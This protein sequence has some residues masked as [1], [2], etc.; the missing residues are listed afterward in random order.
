MS[1]GTTLV[2]SLFLPYTVHFHDDDLPPPRRPS[3]PP[4]TLTQVERKNS[5]VD[6]H[7]QQPA[8][9]F[10]GLSPTPPRT[11]AAADVPEFFTQVQPSAATHFPRPNDPQTLVRSDSH[12]P[13]WSGSGLFFN[14]PRSRAE[15][16]PAG[17]KVETANASYAGRVGRR[18]SPRSRQNR[19]PRSQSKDPR[20]S[21]EWSVVPSPQG[22]GGLSNAIKAAIE[23]KCL[24]DVFMIGLIGF[25]TDILDERKKEEIHEK[26]ESEWDALTVFVSDKDFDGHY[27][28][29]CKIILWPVFHYQIPDHPKSKA[30]GDNSWEFYRNLNQAFANKIVKT[31]KR[32]DIIWVHDYHLLLVPGMIRE[33]LPDAQIGFF[34]H[35]AFP[36]SEVFRC[37]AYRKELL[38]GMLGA[39]LVAFQTHE[40]AHHF[41]QTCSR[42]LSVEATEDGVQLDNHFVNVWSLP[43][44]VYPKAMAEERAKPEVLEWIKTIQ[45]RYAGKRLIVARD[46]LDHIRGVRQ[47]LLAY[48]LFLNKF[49]EWK[50]KVVLIQVATSDQENSDL[51]DTVSEIVTRIESN[52]STLTHHPLVFLKQDIAFS[53]YVALMSVADALMITSLREGMNL[54]CHEFILCQDGKASN[55]KHGPVILSEFTGSASIFEAQ[56]LS[57]NPW[58]YK[59]CANAIKIALEMGP[60]EKERRYMK[61]RNVVMTHTGA[62]WV[63]GLSTHLAKVYEEHFQ[64]DMLSIPRLSFNPLKESYDR[65]Q[66]RLFILDYEGTLTS[67]GS[68]KSTILVSPTKVIDALNE[69]VAD[70]KNLVYV[71]SGRT[72]DELEMIFGRV[73]GL[74]LIAENGCFVRLSKADEW[75]EFLTEAK[76]RRWKDSVR[77]ILQYYVERVEGSSVEERNCSLIFHYYKT[78]EFDDS[79]SRQA[80]DCANHINDAC[81]NQKVRAFPTKDSVIIEPTEFDKGT[82]AAHIMKHLKKE[83][84]PD[85][86]LIAGNDRDDEVIFRWAK[87]MSDSGEVKNV[88]SV[89]VG[90]RNTV[91]M[92]TLTQ[93]TVGLVNVLSKLAKPATTT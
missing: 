24:G 86:L 58:D 93:G 85:F 42:I 76:I 80:G 13:E 7:Q 77:D 8:S 1:Q 5:T 68:V 2:V 6:V 49:P 62:A 71:M 41:L 69:L 30:Y 90:N 33:K 50:D 18:P 54:T 19:T 74:G 39:N 51:N 29:Y 92:T 37:L 9:L 26:L 84:R 88:T 67:Y 27:A 81:V 15:P 14:Q 47:K 70:D 89:S 36:S 10:T 31:Y 55:K 35:A 83:D 52:H 3:P 21:S 43:I 34:L 61:M 82:A 11:P 44:G 25:P 4:R 46:K 66:K 64:R 57:V 16:P 23:S 60:E 22:N 91:A 78:D 53:Q 72:M 59:A 48:E 73:R 40:Y 87:S 32:G 28:H 63:K 56:D 20:W 38:M 45:E 79:S 12:I 65:S 75:T 17:A